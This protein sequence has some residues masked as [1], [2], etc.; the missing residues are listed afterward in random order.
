MGRVG[1]T[2][3][4][5][6]SRTNLIGGTGQRSAAARPSIAD[7]W[8]SN[9]HPAARPRTRLPTTR[10][11]CSSRAATRS[12]VWCAPCVPRPRAGISSGGKA[13]HRPAREPGGGRRYGRPGRANARATRLDSGLRRCGT[14][15][16]WVSVSG[17]RE[18]LRAART[19]V[20]GAGRR[21]DDTPR[22][23][24]SC[25][26]SCRRAL[27]RA[28]GR[29]ANAL[30]RR[31]GSRY[32]R[33]HGATTRGGSFPGGASPRAQRIAFGRTATWGTPA[34]VRAGR[35]QG[36]GAPPG[37]RRHGPRPGSSGTDRSGRTPGNAVS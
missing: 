10:D 6:R 22:P 36:R 15:V 1:P 23:G 11:A 29:I 27:G 24:R 25:V 37:A 21:V 19:G 7:R 14:V 31:R 34:D 32:A 16:G 17:P 8:H 4:G 13:R 3:H 35:L 20:D 33:D 30:A 12:G 28:V 26:L 9:C 5:R 18:R 2:P